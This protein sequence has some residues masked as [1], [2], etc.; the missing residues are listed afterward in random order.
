MP[1]IS[2]ESTRLIS[3]LARHQTMVQA[4]AY[5]IV[6]DFHL[7]EDVYQEVAMVVAQS[8]ASL[9]C[10]EGVL[11]WLREVTRRKA[12]EVSRRSRRGPRSLAPDALEQVAD[13]FTPETSEACGGP[14]LR[15]AMRQCL[16]AL[17]KHALQVVEARYGGS[18]SCEEIATDLRRSVHSVYALLKRAR[19]ALLHCVER[20]QGQE[21]SA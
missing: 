20:R 4:Y 3:F 16:Q 8:S 11:P 7:A 12:L 9:P 1:E 19:I 15:E 2:P 10:G 17:P 6:R 21:A 13:A 5:A 18:R 14:D